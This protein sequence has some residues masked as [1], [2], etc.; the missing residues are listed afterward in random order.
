RELILQFSSSTAGENVSIYGFIKNADIRFIK[1]WID[2]DG[3]EDILLEDYVREEEVTAGGGEE[4]AVYHTG[5]TLG[6][7]SAQL[8]EGIY[9]VEVT[10]PDAEPK[11]YHIIISDKYDCTFYRFDM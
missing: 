4:V 6:D 2:V 10:L 7:I 11:Y 9:T 3:K 5:E 1:G 8:P